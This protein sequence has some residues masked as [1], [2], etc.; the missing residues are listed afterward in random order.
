MSKKTVISLVSCLL[1]GS[2]PA[3]VAGF[4]VTVVVNAVD[5]MFRGRAWSHISE[6]SGEGSKPTVADGDP[7][8]AINIEAP[9]LGIDAALNHPL[10]DAVFAAVRTPVEFMKT[11]ATFCVSVTEI[12]AP[13]GRLSSTNTRTKPVTAPGAANGR[14]GS[15]GNNGKTVERFADHLLQRSPVARRLCLCHDSRSSRERGCGRAGRCCKHLSGPLHC[16]DE[17]YGK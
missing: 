17:D 15:L 7:A 10:P 4:V 12:V 2:C 3:T 14:G 1:M 13:D 11:A 6:E 5:G 8:T 9:V 16:I